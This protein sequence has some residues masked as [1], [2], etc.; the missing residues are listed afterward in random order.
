MNKRE[1]LKSA[2]LLGLSSMIPI[3]GIS[4]V[5]CETNQ[6]DPNACVL[7]PTETAGPFPLDLTENHQYFRQD[8]R[9]DRAGVP[10]NLRL[11]IIS[12]ITC[13]PMQNVRVNIWHCDK[14]GLYSGY[15]QN[16]N[17]GQAGQTYLRG[18]QYTDAFGEVQ[19]KTIFPGWY[20]GRIC[21]IHF[22][23]HVSSSFA[24]I[25]QLT[26][27][28]ATKNAIYA[29]NPGI[30]TKGADPTSLTNDN[31]FSDGYQYQVA[32]LTANSD[33]SYDSYLQ[34]GVNAQVASN[35]GHQEKETAKQ[36]ALGQ[37]F[38]NPY[39]SETTVPFT[40]QT[41]SDIKLELWDLAGRKV[42]TVVRNGLTSGEHSILLSLPSL[43][44]AV[45]N[46]VYQMEVSNGSGV[47]RYSRMMTAGIG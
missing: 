38:P 37:N 30:Y 45:G 6:D 18:Y 36:F 13:Q 17:P 15:S 25:S 16:N 1:F 31:I 2:G 28:V 42:A 11:K 47:F 3:G 8:V 41:R 10:L 44:L 33:G 34:V 43:G 7:T 22:Q 20:S 4:I 12:S 46:Y 26:F 40:L 27:D 19:F 23:V 32:T 35:L 9:E 5:G 14:D 24:A 39:V 29:A 21:H